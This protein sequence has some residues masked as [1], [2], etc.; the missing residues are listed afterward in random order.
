[1]EIHPQIGP[2]CHA[3][4]AQELERRG[5]SVGSSVNSALWLENLDSLSVRFHQILIGRLICKR[6][7]AVQNLGVGTAATSR[8]SRPFRDGT[9][10]FFLKLRRT[11]VILRGT[12]RGQGDMGRLYTTRIETGLTTPAYMGATWTMPLVYITAHR[13]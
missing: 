12:A 6:A 4:C 2:Y 9:G 13:T 5:L 8:S 3:L 7:I 1:M 11:A 10:I